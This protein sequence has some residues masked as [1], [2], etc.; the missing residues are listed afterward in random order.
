[1]AKIEK[2]EDLDVWKEA[3]SIGVEIYNLISS[4]QLAKDLAIKDRLRRAAKSI[5]NNVAEGLEYN[6]NKV[7]VRFL[8]YA[9]GSAGELRS[10]LFVLK[11]AKVL[12]IEVCENLQLKLLH[13][14]ISADLS[15]TSV[16]LNPKKTIKKYSEPLILQSSTP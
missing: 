10:N 7:F 15:K 3:V 13:P 12:S 1:M 11:E 4:G 8:G 6:N 14:K 16:N 5:S 9:K 2:F